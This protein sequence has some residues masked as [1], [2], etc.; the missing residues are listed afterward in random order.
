MLFPEEIFVKF[1]LPNIRIVLANELSK[2]GYSQTQIAEILGITQARVNG[3]LKSNY[4]QAIEGLQKIG[5]DNEDLRLILD[6]YLSE[7]SINKFHT[8]R[9]LY[10]F[11]QNKLISGK[12]CNFHYKVSGLD[13]TC[14]ICLKQDL[15]SDMIENLRMKNELKEA[16]KILSSSPFVFKIIPQINTNI[17][18]SKKKAEKIQDIMAF[19]GRII[20][21]MNTLKILGEPEFGVSTHLAKMLLLAHLKN[22]SIR[23]CTYIKYDETIL[24]IIKKLDLIFDFNLLKEN[25]EDPVV[26]SFKEF[27]KSKGPPTILIDEGRKNYEPVC[28]IFGKNPYE[29]AKIVLL[30]AENYTL[31]F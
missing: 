14:T 3:Y 24:K 22:S 1:F 8:L 19:P 11:W 30:I 29:V 16:F 31:N 13:S 7:E 18:Y 25:K 10:T 9:I 4:N 27:L 23:S 20:R 21:Y 15:A 5:I 2:K 12:I 28:Y 17:V 26:Y 6:N